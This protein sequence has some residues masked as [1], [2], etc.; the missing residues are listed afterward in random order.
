MLIKTR[1]I[2]FRKIH[3]RETSVITDIYTESKGLQSYIVQGVRKPKAKIQ[4]SLLQ[5]MTLVDLVAYDRSDRSLNQVKELKSNYPYRSIPFDL[6]KGAIGMFMVEVMRKA[7]R[8][9]EEQQE[10]F[11]FLYDTF[12]YLDASLETV[13]NLH[14]HFLCALSGYLGFLPS[15]IATPMTPIFSLE[16]GSFVKNAMGHNYWIDEELSQQLSLIL[17]ATRKEACEIPMNRSQ[18]KALLN[19]LLRF[20]QLHIY[21]F[22]EIHSHTI[23]EEIL[24]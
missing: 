19:H 20:Y 9:P 24:G 2:V 11:E 1:G 18:R 5:P 8:E 17:Y 15:G 6:R 22:P 23:L 10:L 3:Y 12:R 7:I 21:N 13:A 16:E 14:L 4:L